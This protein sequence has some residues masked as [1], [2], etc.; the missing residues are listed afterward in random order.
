M[1][2]TKIDRSF[3]SPHRSNTKLK[4]LQPVCVT[5]TTTQLQLLMT[6]TLLNS[7]LI[8]FPENNTEQLKK[9]RYH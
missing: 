3:K 7:R 4:A 2:A 1:F 9:L 6:L 5:T 8:I